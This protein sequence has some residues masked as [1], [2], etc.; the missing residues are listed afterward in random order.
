MSYYEGVRRCT[1]CGRKFSSDCADICSD[2]YMDERRAE[3]LAEAMMRLGGFKLKIEL[4]PSSCW[5][6]NLRN[7]V[8]REVWN[9]Q[10]FKSYY[11]AGYRCSICGVN[12]VLYCHEVWS[13]DD[14]ELV[15]TLEGFVALCEN[16]HMIK[17]IG[18]AGVRASEGKLDYQAL[19]KH[20]MR[21][22]G[23]SYEDFVMARSITFKVWE[24]RSMY[25]WT[26]ELGEY[27]SLVEVLQEQK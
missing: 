17:H 13:Y 15:Q 6:S 12:R 20:F 22:N 24:E 18:Y 10:R 26:C 3:V 21:V 4:V 14:D 1:K 27:K 19:V 23:C 25:D 9:R 16:C 11:E 5:Y 7:A 8:K 2:C